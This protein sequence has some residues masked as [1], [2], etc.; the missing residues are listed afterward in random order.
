MFCPK[1]GQAIEDGSSFCN[2]CGN[3]LSQKT[4]TVEQVVNERKQEVTQIIMVMPSG[5]APLVMGLLGMFGGFIP[6]VKYFTGIL[7]LIAI[8][9]GASQRKR[10]K[11]NN[12]PTGKA[13]AG[14]VLGIIA[15]LITVISIV[16]TA[17][18][19]NSLFGSS[20][21]VK[22]TNNY[23]YVAPVEPKVKVYNLDGSWVGEG[24]RFIFSGEN[25]TISKNDTLLSQGHFIKDKNYSHPSNETDRYTFIW[26]TKW[27]NNSWEELDKPE[28]QVLFITM[29]NEHQF[30]LKNDPVQFIAS[31]SITVYKEYI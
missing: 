28:Q 24:W 14:M 31:F 13:T 16:S 12:L 7:S 27:S 9:V 18:F 30:I 23:T 5:T 21:P 25:I 4:E 22:K 6:I 17:M 29:V 3:N 10:L 20:K 2:K 11:D 1:C 8:F 26:T 15:V 19:L